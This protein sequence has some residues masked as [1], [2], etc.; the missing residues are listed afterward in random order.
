LTLVDTTSWLLVSSLKAEKDLSTPDRWRLKRKTQEL[1]GVPARLGLGTPKCIDFATCFGL[2][3]SVFK[4]QLNEKHANL[5]KSKHR[6]VKVENYWLQ[7]VPLAAL[8]RPPPLSWSLV[9][10]GFAVHDKVGLTGCYSHDKVGLTGCYSHDKVVLTGCY[11]HDKVGLTGCYSH[12][13]V[14]LTGC[15]SH[16]KV[17]LT[18]CYSHDKVGLTGCRMTLSSILSTRA[19]MMSSHCSLEQ[20]NSGSTSPTSTSVPY[21]HPTMVFSLF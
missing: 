3:R 18:G 15:Y 9:E 1:C 19:T 10:F 8:L 12:D 4:H 21:C 7:L 20:W 11:S 14:V 13:K 6:K 17:G 2:S 16:D 5:T